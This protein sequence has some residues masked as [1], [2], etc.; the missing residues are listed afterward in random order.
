MFVRLALWTIILCLVLFLVA[1]IFLIFAATMFAVFITKLAAYSLLIAFTLLGA[2]LLGSLCGTLFPSIKLYFSDVQSG[3]RH[4][5]FLKNRHND[6]RRLFYF[7]N[8]QLIYLRELQRK[9]FLDKTNRRNI[10]MLS[11]AIERDLNRIKNTISEAYYFQ[12]QTENRRYRTQ[13]NITALLEL[14]FKILPL[15]KR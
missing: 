7:Q 14:H 13:Q 11:N 6:K 10:Q 4:F 5:L 2:A 8:L 15:L 3:Q 9:H 12:L 1:K